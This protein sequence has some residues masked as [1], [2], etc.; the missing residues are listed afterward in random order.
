VTVDARCECCD[1]PVSSCGKAAEDKQR[2]ADNA[3]RAELYTRGFI[4]AR[5]PGVCSRCGERFAQDDPIRGT[6]GTGSWIG[7]LCCGSAA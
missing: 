7:G 4:P 3:E 6:Y 5:Y 2:A 1:L